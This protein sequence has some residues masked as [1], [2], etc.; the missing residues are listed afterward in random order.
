M[1]ISTLPVFFFFTFTLD[2]NYKHLMGHRTVFGE[3]DGGFIHMGTDVLYYNIEK[4]TL[5]L[6]VLSVYLP[7]TTSITTPLLP[8]HPPSHTPFSVRELLGPCEHF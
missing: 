2:K 4:H 6:M 5:L 7:C 8:H 3:K 1:E